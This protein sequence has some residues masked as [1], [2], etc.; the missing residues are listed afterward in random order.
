MANPSKSEF[1]SILG[2]TDPNL[3]RDISYIT[4]ALT[5]Q[6]ICRLGNQVNY[7][8][9]VPYFKLIENDERF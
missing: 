2:A 5:F 4:N 8:E 9:D 6:S 3:G 1:E 7:I